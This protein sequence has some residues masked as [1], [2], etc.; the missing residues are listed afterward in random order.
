MVGTLSTPSSSTSASTYNGPTT[1]FCPPSSS[2]Y[3][4]YLA[5]PSPTPVDVPRGTPSVVKDNGFALYLPFSVSTSTV[6]DA[7]TLIDALSIPS[8]KLGTGS[9]GTVYVLSATAGN[10]AVATLTAYDSVTLGESVTLYIPYTNHLPRKV[11]VGLL[12]DQLQQAFET[13][14]TSPP[15][16]ATGGPSSSPGSPAASSALSISAST[17]S[18]SSVHTPPSTDDPSQDADGIPPGALAGGIVGAFFAGLVLCALIFMCLR[19]RKA[20]PTPSQAEE[21]QS[22]TG[23]NGARHFSNDKG[24][25]VATTLSGVTDWTK[26][27]PQDKGDGAISSALESVFNQIQTHVEG[28]YEAKP[29]LISQGDIEGVKRVSSDSLPWTLMQSSDAAVLL[30]AVLVRWVVHRI[31]GRS[32]AAESLLPAELTAIPEMNQ[33]HMERDGSVDGTRSRGQRGFTQAFSQWRKLTGFLAQEPRTHDASRSQL[34]SKIEIAV[35][36]L[37]EALSPWEISRKSKASLSLHKILLQASDAG[38]LLFTQSSSYVFDWSSGEG[39]YGRTLV[40]SPALVRDSEGDATESHR[41][42][43]RRVLVAAKTV[44]A[45]G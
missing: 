34:N 44:K 25:R 20:K 3:L 42:Q 16:V 29:G 11:T 21:D 9:G 12:F 35:Q 28:F 22:S 39:G 17:S 5:D 26:H 30:E 31:S 23:S 32:A 2:P 19:R 43:D 4:K 6:V 14:Q 45:A 15:A 41:M 10:T 24:P 40:V 33:W 7:T 38:T 8:E 37:T 18:R 27:I 13:G 1:I 36:R